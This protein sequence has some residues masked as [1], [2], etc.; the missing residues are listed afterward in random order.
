MPAAKPPEFRRRAVELARQREKPIAQIASDFGIAETCLRRWMKQDDVDSGRTEGVSTDERAELVRLR[1]ELRVAQMEIEILKRAS[2]YFAREN[3]L[4]RW[5]SAGP[6]ARRGRQPAGRCHDGLPS[7]GGLPLGLL[8][9]ARPGAQRSSRGRRAGE[10]HH[11]RGPCRLPRH[12]RGAAGARRAPPRPGAGVRAQAG[13]PA[14]APRRAGLA[15]VCH[16]RKRHRAGPAPAVHADLVQRRFVADAPDRLWVTDITEHP[17]A[18]GKVYSAAVLDVFS[19]VVV[20]WSIADHMRSELV[21]DALEMARW[22]RRP[23]PGAVVHSDRGSQ[24]TSWI[25]GHRL[26][27][28]GLLGS[29]GRVASSVDNGMIESLWSILQREPLDRRSWTTKAEL[30]SA[31]FE[32]IEAVYNARRRHSALGYLSPVQFEALHTPALTAA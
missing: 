26:R 23:E 5:G 27:A 4:P 16:R 11:H 29:M 10:Q 6:R 19:R 9:V 32:W 13:R 12:V 20:G 28:A 21:V 22:R 15:G 3:V 7:A 14:D 30:G 18:E 2:A 25:F 8:R 24:Y 1:R 17:T 31:I